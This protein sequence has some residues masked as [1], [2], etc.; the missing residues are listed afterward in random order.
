MGTKVKI[1]TRWK[2]FFHWNVESKIKVHQ[3]I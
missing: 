1:L 3:Y 2:Q